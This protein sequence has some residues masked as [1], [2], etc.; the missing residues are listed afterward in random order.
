MVDFHFE[1]PVGDVLQVEFGRGELAVSIQK[2]S[3]QSH[4]IIEPRHMEAIEARKW[5]NA[6]PNVT[7][8]QD[9]WQNALANFGVFDSIFFGE[10]P[11]DEASHPILESG[12]KLLGQIKQ[13]MPFIQ[14]I[15]YSDE[16]LDAFISTIQDEEK[17]RQALVFLLELKRND[18]ISIGQLERI[19]G[20]LEKKG[21]LQPR[22]SELCLFLNRCL[23]QHMKIGSRFACFSSRFEDEKGFKELVTKHNV[24]LHS[25]THMLILTKK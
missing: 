24:E 20:V 21:L 17:L 5:A 10:Y 18:Q 23:E 14:A 1:P 8:V 11:K 9:E 22:E 3:P 25:S 4:M 16:D 15:R 19:F 13:K 2:L 12:K 6:H 7:V